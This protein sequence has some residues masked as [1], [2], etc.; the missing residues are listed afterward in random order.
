M[1][2]PDEI[3]AD[4]ARTRAELSENV[5]ALGDSTKPGNIVRSQVD[6]VKEGAR[7]LKERIFGGNDDPYDQY[8]TSNTGPG[9]RD[10]ASALMD[11]A[12]QAVSDAPMKVKS[13][14]RGNPLAAGLVAAG[15]GALIGGLI[16]PTRFEKEKASEIADQAQ[17]LVDEVKQLATEAKDNLAPL[18]SEAAESVK[19]TAQTAADEVKT[20]AT[21]A[22]DEVADQ[23]KSSADNVKADAQSAVDETK[24]EVDE[25]RD[26][27][28]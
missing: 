1:S 24:S 19:G 7:N 18:A 5:N 26:S 22:K 11:D 25:K 8:A 23:A 10:K 2:N 28:F 16:P 13:S 15:I 21:S 6:D 17:P 20:E 14:T 4:I 27:S 9:V 12:G 3:R